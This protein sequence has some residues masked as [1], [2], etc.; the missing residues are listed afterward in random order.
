MAQVEVYVNFLKFFSAYLPLLIHSIPSYLCLL[1][2]QFL[3]AQL[4]DIVKPFLGF[5]PLNQ[6]LKSA[7]S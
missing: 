7:Q 6:G 4:S 2:L 3:H 1:K 5:S